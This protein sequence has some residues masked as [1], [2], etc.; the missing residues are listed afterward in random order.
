MARRPSTADWASPAEWVGLYRGLGLQVVPCHR[1]AGADDQR[2]SIRSSRPGSSSRA[3]PSRTVFTS[4]GTGPAAS[5]LRAPRWACSRARP[6]G[7]TV[8]IDLDTVKCPE[9]A[10]WW[11]GLLTSRTT[12]ASPRPGKQS[13]APAAGTVLRVSLGLRH[14]D[15][16][17]AIGVDLRGQGGFIVSRAD[18]PQQW[19]GVCLGGRFRALAG[20]LAAAP[21]WLI[22][23]IEELIRKHGGGGK[24]RERTAAKPNSI[25]SAAASTGV[26]P[27][28]PTPSGPR[29]STVT[30]SGTSRAPRPP[31]PSRN[32]RGQAFA[33]YR[34]NVG[35][36]ASRRTARARRIGSS[37]KAAAGPPSW[38]NGVP[39]F[40][41]GIRRSPRRQRS[42]RTIP[43]K[44]NH[45]R[46]S[47]PVALHAP[48]LC[49]PRSPPAAPGV[50]YGHTI[51]GYLSLLVAPGGTGKT[52]LAIAECL[53]MVIGQGLSRGGAG[54]AAGRVLVRRGSPR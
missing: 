26:R 34:D 20:D 42:R 52:T 9:A 11:R 41:S 5:S 16:E 22:I 44:S 6:P 36:R 53:D 27:I 1:P 15:C 43:S 35:S 28:W 46:R 14:A 21:E 7:R 19:P 25:P 30:V 48:T 40:V 13:L 8:C 39:L 37:A 50:A 54:A 2:G 38:P 49:L 4:A 32:G 24:S 33:V 51:R 3:S 18:R 45:R 10:Q 17:D 23:A 47:C 29:S 12:A 31:A